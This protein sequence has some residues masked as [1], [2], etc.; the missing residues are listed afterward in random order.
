MEDIVNVRQYGR[1]YVGWSPT[2]QTYLLYEM[3]ANGPMG[4]NPFARFYEINK[5]TY[6]RMAEPGFDPSGRI[7]YLF[8]ELTESNSPAAQEIY[9]R[10]KGK[11]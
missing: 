10:F 3:V 8:D 4:R 5:E 7:S 6:D 9:K 1:C 11:I 2:L